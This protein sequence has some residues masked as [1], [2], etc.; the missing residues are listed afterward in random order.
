VQP[1]HYDSFAIQVDGGSLH[2]GRWGTGGPVLLAAHGEDL[3]AVLDH[4]GVE[5]ATVVGHS[6][7]GFVAAVAA[8]RHP[9]RVE[10]LVLVDGSLPLDLGG[11]SSRSSPP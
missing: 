6:M 1:L 8:H 4:A 11:R 9:E 2:V 5:R 7:G 3:V 10:R